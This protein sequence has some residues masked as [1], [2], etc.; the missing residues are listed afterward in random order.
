MTAIHMV[1]EAPEET[2]WLAAAL[3]AAA[4]PNDVIGLQGTL[5]A[6][7][8]CFAQ[9]FARGLG[10]AETVISPTFVLMRSYEGRLTLHHFDAYRLGGA[11][12]MEAIGCAEVFGSGGVS[13]IEW[14]DHV[15]G[16]LPPDHFLLTLRAAGERRRELALRACGGRCVARL[17]ELRG[18]L[19]PWAR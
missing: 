19:A 18:V 4:R 14:A 5:G 15:A 3:A 13:L 1:T 7:K 6:G 16:C 9:G 12:D 17:G 11:D 8:T 10:V 2:R